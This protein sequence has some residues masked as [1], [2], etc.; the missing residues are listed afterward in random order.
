MNAATNRVELLDRTGTVIV[1]LQGSKEHVADG[2]LSEISR[3]WISR[4][5]AA[6]S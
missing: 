4:R 5:E 2:I 1:T 3:R 6:T